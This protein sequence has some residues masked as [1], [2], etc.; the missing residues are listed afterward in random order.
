MRKIQNVEHDRPAATPHARGAAGAAGQQT[1]GTNPG[2]RTA[3]RACVARRRAGGATREEERRVRYSV[4]VHGVRIVFKISVPK[5][6]QETCG[7]KV[8]ER[9]ARRRQ[10][11][12][13]SA[14]PVCKDNELNSEGSAPATQQAG[15]PAP[16]ARTEPSAA[17]AERPPNSRQ[18]RSARRLEDFMRAKRPHG[19]V[20]AS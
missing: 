9:L 1:T 16:T 15:R 4:E 20:P 14:S 11:P 13:T 8:Q 19:A 5:P 18:R 6:S 7:G 17:R 2:P 3:D 12:T 10:E